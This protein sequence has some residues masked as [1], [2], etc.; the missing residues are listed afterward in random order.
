MKLEVKAPKTMAF[1]LYYV[2]RFRMSK[3]GRAHEILEC[4]L[5][6]RKYHGVHRERCLE[7]CESVS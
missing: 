4:R 7:V 3:S 2:K 1:Y 6:Q 5:E